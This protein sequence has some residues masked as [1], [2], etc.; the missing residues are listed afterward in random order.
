MLVD[1]EV[2]VDETRMHLS[3][4]GVKH[5]SR[6]KRP[7]NLR[8]RTEPGDPAPGNRNGT[9]RK[10]A[11]ARVERQNPSIPHEEVAWRTVAVRPWRVSLIV[12]DRLL[13][14]RLSHERPS[15]HCSR[16]EYQI[17]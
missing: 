5:A 15:A 7:D 2:A 12:S 13:R 6:L 16:S 9:I 11:S 14:R 8:F 3:T 10:H 1:V 4:S 17:G